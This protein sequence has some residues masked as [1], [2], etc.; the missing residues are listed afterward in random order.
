MKLVR[1]PPIGLALACVPGLVLA[2]R[3]EPTAVAEGRVPAT[4][5]IVSA[6]ARA[7]AVYAVLPLRNLGSDAEAARELR[8]G[9]TQLLAKRGARIVADDAL[10][11]VLRAR[12]VR[13]TDS[14]SVADA[15]AVGE[16]TGARYA[17]AGV[18]FDFARGPEPRV[19]ASLRVIDLSTG[20][21]VQSAFVSLRGEDSRGL[22]GLGAIEDA[23]ELVGLAVSRFARTFGPD[24]DPAALEAAGHA[25]R[26]FDKIA[27]LPFVNRS[28]RTDAGTTFSEILGHAW[29]QETGVRTIEMSELRSALVRARIRSLQET[30]RASMASI[31]REL[32]ARWFVLGSVDRFGEEVQVRDQRYPVIEATV[33][34]VDARTGLVARSRQVRLR[35][36]DGE[37]VLR[38]GVEHDPLRLAEDAAREL[39]RELEGGS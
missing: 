5:G 16:A 27:L 9:L 1:F 37:T 22:L 8:D 19:S 2:V 39:V 18:L 6:P 38:L 12:R 21:R 32:D 7:N 4:A 31:G 17:L 30:D 26:A 11:A 15:R 13:Y 3:A 20:E 33:R 25:E 10:E 36:D 28:S 34:V 14:L 24:G 35:G 29:F 23:H